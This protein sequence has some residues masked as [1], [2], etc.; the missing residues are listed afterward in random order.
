MPTYRAGRGTEQG[1]IR[2]RNLLKEAEE[3][4]L[5]LG[6]RTPEIRKFLHPTETL[7][8]DALLWQHQSDGLVVFLFSGGLHYYRLP[9]SFDE[10]VVPGE[11]FHLKPLFPLFDTDQGFFVLAVSQNEVRLLK[12]TQHSVRKI[13]LKDMPTSLAQALRFDDPEKRPQFHTGTSTPGAGGVRSALFHGHGVGV[14]DAK[15]NILRYFHKVDKG[16][17]ELFR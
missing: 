5:A 1:P 2:L 12:C 7:L 8:G 14:D 10:L 4:L 11:R 13:D 16:L 3:Q 9:L 15:S 17:Q 6:F